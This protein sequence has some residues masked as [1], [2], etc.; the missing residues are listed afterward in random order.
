[1]RA[2]K[3]Y[4]L[5][6]TEEAQKIVDQLTL[7]QKVWLMSG[8]IDFTTMTP[9]AMAA[10]GEMM[11]GPDNHYNVTPYD[12]GGLSEHNVPPMLFCDGPR[13]LS[14]ATGRA[15]VSPSPWPAAPPLT[16]LSRK[17]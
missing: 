4:R 5:S 6:L 10:M 1:M 3:K 9:E 7:E 14:A 2:T 15:L 12:A 17:R 16:P 13:G 8:N 11:T